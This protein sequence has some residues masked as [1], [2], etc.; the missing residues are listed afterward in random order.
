MYSSLRQ[1]YVQQSQQAS[2]EIFCR[3]GHHFNEVIGYTRGFQGIRC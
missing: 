2:G 3:D 1:W